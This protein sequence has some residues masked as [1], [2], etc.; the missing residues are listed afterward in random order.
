MI[1]NLHV[2]IDVLGGSLQQASGLIL[3]F[4][5]IQKIVFLYWLLV[6]KAISKVVILSRYPGLTLHILAV[7]I[8]INLIR[9]AKSLEL[10][11]LVLILLD[12][13][14]FILKIVGR[15]VSRLIDFEIALKRHLPWK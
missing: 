15:L 3:H 9:S 13:Q 8:I 7:N 11:F 1:D 12:K 10:L 14:R 5:R 4:T 2:G 6:R